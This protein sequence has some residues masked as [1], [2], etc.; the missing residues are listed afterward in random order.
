VATLLLTSIAAGQDSARPGEAFGVVMVVSPGEGTPY[1][2]VYKFATGQFVHFEQTSDAQMTITHPGGETKQTNESQTWKQLRVVSVDEHGLATLEPILT[3]VKMSAQI[4]NLNPVAFDSADKDATVPKEFEEVVSSIGNAQ[5]RAVFTSNGELVKMTLLNGAS[6]KMAA[7]A[8]KADPILNF[9][10]VLPKDPVG[11]GAVWKD[12]F[13]APVSVG[14]NLSQLVTLQRQYT[15]AKVTG[16]IATITSRISVMT[17]LSDP[18]IEAQLCQRTP[19]G[20]IEFDLDRG[21]VVSQTASVN[22]QVVNAFGPMTV[23]QAKTETREKLVHSTA[24]VQP[25]ALRE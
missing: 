23:L 25:A 12:R 22:Q 24:A 9:L 14:N 4:A 11:V 16:S 7:Q 8:A 10:V 13:Q 6:E 15:L 21:L 19:S 17:P 5:S 1:R 20:V 2:L 18:A 3:R